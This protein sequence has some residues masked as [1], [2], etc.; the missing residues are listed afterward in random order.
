M[1]Q[2]WSIR[3]FFRYYARADTRYNVHSPYLST[4][5]KAL[6][7]ANQLPPDFLSD[8]RKTLL[9][10]GRLIPVKNF[11]AGSRV[12]K[13]RTEP[14]KDIARSALSTIHEG[15]FLHRLARFT[16]ASLQLE[17]GTSLGLSSLNMQ[18]ACP[19]SQVVSIEAH[20]E[21]AD[22][23]RQLQDQSPLRKNPIILNGTFDDVLPDWLASLQQDIDL[24]F[25]DGDHTYQSTVANVQKILPCM[26]IDGV[27]ALHDIYWSP[28]M[29]K[30]WEHC[31]NLPRVTAT[32]DLFHMGLLILRPRMMT[33]I[34]LTM[35]DFW[36][37]P[38]KIGLF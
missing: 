14:V 2:L 33:P 32:I 20:P 8:L 3:Q 30:A 37:K 4:L 28:E 25:I 38:W 16:Q 23:A 27:I 31:K 36:K 12:R 18:S 24:A 13:S 9:Q 29:M 1:N 7:D 34:H 15:H 10:D 19:D 35:I 26:S 5:I 22:L 17:L 6:Y 21:L 11:G